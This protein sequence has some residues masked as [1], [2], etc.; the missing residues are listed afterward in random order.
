MTDTDEN[1]RDKERTQLR[2]MVSPLYVERI[3]Y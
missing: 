2:Q 3:L 1:A